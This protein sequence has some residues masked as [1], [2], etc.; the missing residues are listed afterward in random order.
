MKAEKKEKVEQAKAVEFLE[1]RFHHLALSSRR[2]VEAWYVL[3]GGTFVCK[4]ALDEIYSTPPFAA[5]DSFCSRG[6]V[7]AE[8]TAGRKVWRT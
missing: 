5:R 2:V 1:R 3:Y 6:G 8:K 7:D 4:A